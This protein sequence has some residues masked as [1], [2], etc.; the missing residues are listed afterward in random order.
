MP[1]PL[2]QAKD[3]LDQALLARKQNQEL[4]KSIGPA[5]IETLSPI[6]REV[7]SNSKLSKDELLSAI[8]GIKI[9][10]PK[11]DLSDAQLNVTVPDIKVPTPQVHYTPPDIH[12]PE[13][14]IPEIR[15]PKPEVTVNLPEIKVPKMEWPS[16][17]M[18]IE[19][20]VNLMGVDLAH[21]LPVQ[22]RD[23]SGKPVTLGG[24]SVAFGGGGGGGQVRI[25]N[26]AGEPVPVTGTFSA[27][28]SGSSLSAVPT[29]AEGLTYNSDNPL[30][31]T[32]SFTSTP[33]LQISGATDS[34]NVAM[35]GGNVVPTGLN[36]TTNGVMRTVQMTDSVSSVYITGAATSTFAEIMNPDGRVR[37]ELP[38]G[39]SGLTNTE[40]RAATIDVQQV[41]G[42]VTSTNVLSINGVTP[43]VGSGASDTGSL[44]VMLATD[45]NLSTMTQH[46]AIAVQDLPGI[47][48]FPT[49]FGG[50][51]WQRQRGALGDGASATGLP[52]IVPMA[53]NAAGTNDRLRNF[54]GEGGALRVQM[55]T[56]A[57]ASVNI[58]NTT[59]AV[60]DNSGSL[61][62]DNAGTFAIQVQDSQASTITSHQFATD[63]RG[64]DVYVGGV[65]NSTT[66]DILTPDNRMKIDGS[67]VTQPVSGTFF[68]ST[69]PVSIAA[70]TVVDQVSGANWSVT[71]SQAGTWNIGTVTTVTGVTNTVTTRLDSPDGAYSG[72]NP[73][74]VTLISGALTSTISVGTTLHDGVD[75]GDAPLKTGGVAIQTVPAAVSDGDRVRFLGDDLGRQ[76][77]RATARDLLVTAYAQLTNGTETSLIAG[78]A[79]TYL[80]MVYIMGA[81]NSD[82]AV[83]IDFRSGTAGSV[84]KTIEIPAYGTAGVAP[85]QPIPMSEVAQAWTADMPDI[86]GTTVSLTGLF[87]KEK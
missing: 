57:V 78:V 14:K 42:S 82:A 62:V 67:G 86:T 35:Y 64:L 46:D 30:P 7:S 51:T 13:I 56:D 85:P 17:R 50:T 76:L 6:L 87:N 81:N 71:A 27:S 47:L 8:A 28:F 29:N 63:S 37:V 74:P 41:S 43:S 25:T 39:A 11:P 52:N 40:L 38:T 61:T 10:V 53:I 26:G 48:N 79:S 18:P 84:V 58:T 9:N 49:I 83:S 68:Q 20:W 4:L 77:V 69:Q 1:N 73:F 54:A 21:P 3:A 22:L 23:A 34:V 19:G 55:A 2:Q 66:A 24:G 60:T 75:D 31:V 32:G 15:V 80:D 70:T 16:E 12:I 33:G 65:F 5:V 36:E 44:R 45:A 72:S 59:I